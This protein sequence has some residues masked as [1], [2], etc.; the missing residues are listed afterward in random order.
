[1]KKL[2][3]LLCGLFI[4]SSGCRDDDYILR[5]SYQLQPGVSAGSVYVADG[6]EGY[7]ESSDSG[8]RSQMNGLV[9]NTAFEQTFDDDEYGNITFIDSITGELTN[10]NSKEK[11]AFS[12]FQIDQAVIVNLTDSSKILKF[13]L[14][15][16]G[17]SIMSCRPVLT[18][19]EQGSLGP[20]E[21]IDDFDCFE[22]DFNSDEARRWRLEKSDTIGI[23]ELEHRSI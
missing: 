4:I 5:S 22:I 8:L 13:R 10:F 3:L 16:G 6:E 7:Q 20:I 21:L 23:F 17:K 12:F 9:F 15:E 11:I 18:W 1:M 2:T 14:S 19:A